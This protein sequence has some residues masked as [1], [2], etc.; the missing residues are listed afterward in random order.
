MLVDAF[1]LTKETSGNDAQSF[2]PPIATTSTSNPMQSAKKPST[3]LGNG[4]DPGYAD[5]NEICEAR[6]GKSISNPAGRFFAPTGCK[7]MLDLPNIPCVMH[8]MPGFTAFDDPS[9]VV[10]GGVWR[11]DRSSKMR[12]VI[13][14]LGP[15]SAGQRCALPSES[16]SNKK[17]ERAMQETMSWPKSQRTVVGAKTLDREGLR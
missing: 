6:E 5:A 3:E 13:R 10:N 17:R 12:V 7:R 15:T 11:F 8:A 2:H 14:S 1:K 9:T 16:D 4:D